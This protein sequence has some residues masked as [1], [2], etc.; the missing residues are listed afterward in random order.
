VKKSG[1]GSGNIAAASSP[2]T[3]TAIPTGGMTGRSQKPSHRRRQR[4]EALTEKLKLNPNTEMENCGKI[5]A[6]KGRV[7]IARRFNAGNESATDKFRR[8]G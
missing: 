8:N 6:L 5:L 2:R 3:A 1:R 4:E 7:T